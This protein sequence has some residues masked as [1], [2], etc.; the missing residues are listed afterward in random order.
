MKK[1]LK[2]KLTERVKYMFTNLTSPQGL[3]KAIRYQDVA[4]VR[5]I[6]A[7]KISPNVNYRGRN[8]LFEALYCY[9]SART[10]GEP[11][12]RSNE[13]ITLLLQ[14]GADPN[15]L[16]PRNR[17]YFFHF[18]RDTAFRAAVIFRLPV[19]TLELMLAKGADP[20]FIMRDPPESNRERPEKSLLLEHC[21]ELAR[22]PFMEAIQRGYPEIF[23]LLLANGGDV[24]SF[25]NDGCTPLYCYAKSYWGA[26]HKIGE[27]LIAAGAQV[28]AVIDHTKGNTL[29][30]KLCEN[31]KHTDTIK[32]LL[33][34]GADPCRYNNEGFAPVHIAARGKCAEILN[35][36]LMNGGDINA[37]DRA[38]N[39]ALIHAVNNRDIAAIN[40]LIAHHA[41]KD[42]RNIHGETAMDLAQQLDVDYYGKLKSDIIKA[43]G[44]AR[45][46]PPQGR[47]Y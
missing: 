30:L 43:L 47:E 24:N 10:Y 19:A 37:R 40:V 38:D 41:D 8:P 28:D 46:K 18:Y 31:N 7:T 33:Y 29:L 39:T 27:A 35:T 45:S 12:G 22:S 36:L 23:E 32:F 2:P 4:M 34:H 1:E 21:Y 9:S 44:N 42:C 6:L 11:L 26:D 5:K 16:I 25:G 3:V 15:K 17:N 20:N 14:K 13:I